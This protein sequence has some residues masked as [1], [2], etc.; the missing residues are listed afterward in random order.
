MNLFTIPFLGRNHNRHTAG[1]Q[2]ERGL[3]VFQVALHRQ[4][5]RHRQIGNGRNQQFRNRSSRVRYRSQPQHLVRADFRGGPS[6]RFGFVQH[7]RLQR[8]ATDL[9]LPRR[10]RRSVNF[11]F[12]SIND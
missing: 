6:P 3:Q 8:R 12:I 2:R 7:R 11:D 5:V 9:H 10:R 1:D 4:D